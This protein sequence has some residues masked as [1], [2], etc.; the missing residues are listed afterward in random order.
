MKNIRKLIIKISLFILALFLGLE[1]I[2]SSAAV[3]NGATV[4]GNGKAA[5]AQQYSDVSSYSPSYYSSVEGLTGDDLLEGLATLSNQKH[6]TYTTY[7]QI[8]GAVCYSDADPTNPGYILDFYTQT[9][10]PNDYD[11]EFWNREHVWCQNLSA[12]TYGTTGAGADIH[13]IRPT[14]KSVNSSRSDNKYGNL[15]KSNARY[16]SIELNTVD[17]SKT[18]SNDILYG[19]RSSSAFE[20]IDDV[21]GDVARIVMYVYMHYS[22]EVSA[23]K[24]GSYKGNLPITNVIYASSEREAWDLLINWNEL[25]PVDPFEMNRNDY[26]ASVTGLRNPFIDHQDYAEKIWSEDYYTEGDSKDDEG[27]TTPPSTSDP[28]DV[29]P[30]IPTDPIITRI[31][32]HTM[33]E[34][35][36]TSQVYYEEDKTEALGSRKWKASTEDVC[37]FGYS[38]DRGQ[39]FGLPSNYD[40]S[41]NDPTMKGFNSLLFTVTTPFEDITSIS[42]TTSGGEGTTVRLEMFVGSKTKVAT[43][44]LKGT[45]ST[46]IYDDFKKDFPDGISGKVSFHYIQ[47]DVE[48]NQRDIYIKS[49]KIGYYE[50]EEKK[51]YCDF[52]GEFQTSDQGHWL[53]C[54]DP[55]CNRATEIKPHG[56]TYTTV[57]PATCYQPEYL[58]GVCI[59]GATHMKE[60]IPALGHDVVVDKRLD[61]TCVTPGL[62]EGS[63]CGRCNEVIKA[64]EEI[65][66]F[67]HVF[68]K[69]T[70]ASTCTEQGYTS[71][72]CSTCN[73]TYNDTHTNPLGHKYGTK[74]TKPTCTE[75]GYKTRTCSRCSDSYRDSYTAPLGH[76]YAA[77]VTKPKCETE[78]YTKHTCSRCK[79]YYIDSYVSPLGHTSIPV[80]GKA[81]TCTATGLTKGYKCSACR[82][83]LTSQKTIPA[84]GHTEVTTYGY[85]PTCTTK[86]KT[87]G[88]KCD[89]CSKTLKSQ[90]SIAALG[91]TKVIDVGY[92][93]TCEEKGL[94]DGSHCSVCNAEILAQ[95]SIAALGHSYTSVLTEPTCEL[96]GYTNHTCSTCNHS[97]KDAKVDALGHSYIHEIV[98]PKCE[99]RGY[100]IHKCTECEH[101]YKD[102]YIN[103]LGHVE[104]PVEGQTPT[105]VLGG[106]TSGVKCERCLEFTFPQEEIPA[107]GHAEVLTFPG[108]SA[109]CT[110]PGVSDG[111]YCSVC[112]EVISIGEENLPALGHDIIVDAAVAPTCTEDGLTEGSHCSR[113]DYKVAQETVPLLG[114][115][116]GETVIN[117]TCEEQGYTLHTCSTC[118]DSY[119]DNFKEKLGH[120][121]VSQVIDPTCLTNGYTTHTCS[122]CSNS[123]TS[124]E[125]TAL[126]HSYKEVVTNPIC[127]LGGYTTYTCKTCNDTYEDNLVGALG[128]NIVIDAAVAPDCVNSGLSE[129]SHC[130]RCDYK[131]DQEVVPAVG[132]TVVTDSAVERTCIRPGLTEGSHCSV[133]NEV[134][135]KQEIL[136]PL[137]HSYVK[138]VIEVTCE[139]DGCT[140]YTCSNCGDTYTENIVVSLGHFEYLVPGYAP[141]CTEVGY[142]DGYKC[143]TCLEF[144]VPQEEIPALGHAEVITFAGTPATC[145]TPGI[146]DGKYCSVCKEVL[147]IGEENLPALGHDIIVDVAVAPTCEEDGLTEGSHCSRCEY[148]VEQEKISKRGHSYEEEVIDP[149]CDTEGYT[150]H[151]CST[152]G[153]NYKDNICEATKH[154]SVTV[155]GKA[156]TCTETGLTDWEYCSV[157]L[158]V[159]C[160]QRE[161]EC[162]GHKEVVVLGTPATCTET[163]LTDWKYCEVC[164]TVLVAQEEVVALGH[165]TVIDNAV[166]ATCVTSG[167]SEGSH[168]ST[169]NTVLVEQE[170]IGSLGHSYSSV[171]TNPTCE[172]KGYTTHTCS[173]CNDS[174]ID[175]YV[176]ELGHNVV[177]DQKVE[178]TCI[179]DGLTEGSHCSVCKEV[180]V[181]Q[182]VISALGHTMSNEYKYD[183]E[184][185]WHECACGA[186]DEKVAHT[187]GEA[188]E[189]EKAICENCNQSYGEL[190]AT[191]SNEEKDD[192]QED[193]IPE[194]EPEVP[195]KD[196]EDNQEP[197]ED[198][199]PLYQKIIIPAVIGSISLVGVIFI[200]KRLF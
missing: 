18:T 158:D 119:K 200:I 76:N 55:S 179:K 38:S 98:D 136:N 183:G 189:E 194:Q 103:A 120:D 133:C 62:T 198:N 17:E 152:C 149:S 116:Y 138:T 142:T 90:V 37:A 93:A 193:Q 29:Y 181:E 46:F 71:H 164:H 28:N 110:T 156:P 72:I 167:L 160:D 109:T 41:V 30:E 10:I 58:Q 33:Y 163:G 6:R 155:K 129:G 130:S 91:H 166:P 77:K 42:I 65:E 159:L 165:S 112:N 39:R 104:V 83:V 49:I 192:S 25:D 94:T 73:Y 170:E 5:P 44:E 80:E 145:T 169:C 105:C 40:Y 188:T 95:K 56:Y 154:V 123:Y 121:Y 191:S 117:S 131:V 168:C 12:G 128:H 107:L 35:E 52:S 85:A 75:Q 2:L 14:F 92:P 99:E 187:G 87:D 69:V 31:P 141:T 4:T 150:L 3:V 125:V 157:C 64:Q 60:G 182:E 175:T 162:L 24:S 161:I 63:H 134:F 16:Y 153:D 79:D 27:T 118:L 48:E 23:N 86:G 146:S 54:T 143:E 171:I 177:T 197:G 102:E 67:G 139:V 36:F 196:K 173:S 66:P 144:T 108:T 190:K 140:K 21:K 34:Y 184:F 74:T 127:I 174:Y 135:T 84:L 57:S 20:P 45:T 82:K 100:T 180:L 51:H 151:T 88:V 8:W 172:E 22:K 78:G 68:A 7:S 32:K 176:N 124:N 61:P 26:C 114:H 9:S 19:Y 15:G 96:E 199:V 185:H 101:E 43:R 50:Y 106:F 148:K 111:K 132:H 113:C 186:V 13:H 178:A 147:S 126:G 122:R 97:Y 137:G 59:C 11:T 195:N 115:S 89:V 70:V 1:A 53:V 81:P 47:T